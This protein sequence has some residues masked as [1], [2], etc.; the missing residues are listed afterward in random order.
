MMGQ[1]RKAIAGPSYQGRHGG[2]VKLPQQVQRRH[3]TYFVG[4]KCH[5]Q[6]NSATNAQEILQRLRTKAA[7][8]LV[9]LLQLVQ[10]HHATQ[11]LGPSHRYRPLVI[12]ANPAK[13]AEKNAVLRGRTKDARE[14]VRLPQLV[15]RHRAALAEAADHDALH[16]RSIGHLFLYQAVHEPAAAQRMCRRAWYMNKAMSK[17]MQNIFH[18]HLVAPATSPMSSLSQRA[19]LVTYNTAFA[20]EPNPKQSDMYKR[21]LGVYIFMELGAHAAASLMPSAS[22][23]RSSASEPRSWMSNQPGIGMPMFTLMGLCANT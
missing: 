18:C 16:R 8:E 4:T 6:R 2:R 10:R 21:T 20:P 7:S 14:L 23:V 13:H 17:R 12:D 11:F 15:Q 22:S 19:S 9:N 1:V 5:D 3:T